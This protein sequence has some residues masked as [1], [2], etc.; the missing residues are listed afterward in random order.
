MPHP[1]PGG[2]N[3]DPHQRVWKAEAIDAALAEARR[4][5]LRVVRDPSSGKG[6]HDV[7]SMTMEQILPAAIE[8]QFGSLQAENDRLAAEGVRLDERAAT[9]HDRAQTQSEIIRGEDGIARRYS[10]LLADCEVL[11]EHMRGDPVYRAARAMVAIEAAVTDAH[12]DDVD[13]D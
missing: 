2:R 6:V 4:H 5:G 9:L 3:E 7:T 12:D 13:D 1:H 8:R 10:Q 11:I